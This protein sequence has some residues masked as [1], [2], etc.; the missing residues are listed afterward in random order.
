SRGVYKGDLEVFPAGSPVRLTVGKLERR[1][2]ESADH[3]PGVIELLSPRHENYPTFESASILTT[4]GTEV[5]LR[6]SVISSSRKGRAEAKAKKPA[7]SVA[8]FVSQP[9]AA[10]SG[11]A[12]VLAP[13]NNREAQGTST[14]V[15]PR[16]G[17][18]IV[19]EGADSARLRA[20]I[21]DTPTPSL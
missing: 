21:S 12:T 10:S 20:S 11:S 8:S 17:Q 7:Q 13:E 14:P 15:K 6:V 9:E 5:P 1:K 4:G 19:L 18:T 16:V 3:W 2:R